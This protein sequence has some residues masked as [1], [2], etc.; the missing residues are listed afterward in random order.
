[1]EVT[2][3]FGIGGEDIRQFDVE[4]EDPDFNKLLYAFMYCLYKSGNFADSSYI[5]TELDDI[6]TAR[7]TINITNQGGT[8]TVS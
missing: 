4:W 7:Y 8:I 6:S 1:M 3:L 2:F 5:K